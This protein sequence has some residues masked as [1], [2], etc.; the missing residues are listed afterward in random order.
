MT[1][2]D[3]CCEI[4]F[5]FLILDDKI[6]SAWT[7]LRDYF[8]D[9]WDVKLNPSMEQNQY[10]GMSTSFKLNFGSNVL[11]SVEVTLV[12]TRAPALI[13]CVENPVFLNKFDLIFVD[14]QWEELHSLQPPMLG[15]EDLDIDKNRVGLKIAQ[16]IKVIATERPKIAMF[17]QYEADALN[18]K[19][20]LEYGADAYIMKDSD[21]HITSV[22]WAA[23][24]SARRKFSERLR[25]QQQ[26]EFNPNEAY[27]EAKVSMEIPA[28][29]RL[30]KIFQLFEGQPNEPIPRSSIQSIWDNYPYDEAIKMSE[31]N[32]DITRLTEL[33]QRYTPLELV[34]NQEDQTY[35]LSRKR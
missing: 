2:E 25:G 27:W 34:E 14:W 3:G 29:S 35:V 19:Q 9:N 33:L 31:I 12:G 23:V 11:L 10:E 13:A 26:V 21:T 30:N 24:T 22:F 1:N 17:S 7:I 8:E 6:D 20:A 18:I 5:H 32:A 4:P 28:T 15:L 16:T